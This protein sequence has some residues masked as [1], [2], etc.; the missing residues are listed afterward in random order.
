MI[1]S[2]F[3]Y[4]FA[5]ILNKAIPFLLL[6][7]LT[8]YLTVED[9]GILSVFQV[10]LAFVVPVVGMNM[11]SNITRNYA[12]K[13]REE[14]ALLIG[15]L[16][17]VLVCTVVIAE[18]FF[19]LYFTFQDALFGITSFWI[20]MLPPVAGLNIVNQFNT[21][22]LRNQER[23]AAFGVFQIINTVINLTVSL[24]LI[25]G[26]GLGWEGRGC[27]VFFTAFCLGL[28][29]LY[30]IHRQ[31]L[32]SFSFNRGLIDEILKI[33]IP[34][35]PHGVGGIVIGLSDRLF[36]D[37][38]VSKEAVGLYTVGYTFGMIVNLF[39]DSF[40]RAWAPWFHKQMNNPKSDTHRNIVIYTYAYFIGVI[41]LAIVMAFSFEFI[42]P[43]MVASDFHSATK[44][45]I[46]IAIGY[47]FRGMY[48]MMFPY[49]IF[50]AHTRFLGYVTGTTAIINIVLNYVFISFNGAIG[51]AQATLF[52]WF[53]MFILTWIYAT[54][55]CPMPWL[56]IFRRSV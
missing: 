2:A 25:V 48:T 6:P 20:L 35:I 17:I 9:Y 13:S 3:I 28:V 30:Y 12:K 55:I 18:V 47:A 24:L 36:I 29:G 53:L 50:K 21:T 41:L 5:G 33:S 31:G 14:M 23:A 39:V 4:L 38:M 7:V 45:I 37:Q 40:S 8:R 44:F 26:F 11:Q 56:S 16:I 42:L 34:L 46:W 1:K 49:L 27:A 52:A 22:I 51:A 32:I 43:W 19:V 15:N 10:L 54:R